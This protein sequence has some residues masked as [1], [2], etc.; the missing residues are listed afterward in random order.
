MRIDG[1]QITGSFNL[2]GDTIGDLDTLVTTSSLNTYTSSMDTTM[3]HVNTATHSLNTFT[4]SATTR[5]NSI[6]TSS[7]S[8]NSYTSSNTTNINAIHTSTGSLNTFTSS[9]T[10]RLSSIETSTGSLNTFT[11]S[12]TTR[13]DNIEGVSG[14]YATTGSNQFKNDQVITGSLTVTGFIETQ[15]LRTTYISSSILYRSGSTK[16]G[17]ELSDTHAFTGSMLISG[18]VT[19]TGNVG[20]GGQIVLNTSN[21]QIRSGNELRFYRPDNAIYT[22][23]YDGGGANGFVID[24]RNGDGFSLQSVGTNQLRISSTGAATFS[25]SVTASG[26][27]SQFVANGGN[28]AG[29]GISL[30]TT[31]TTN[32]TLRRNWG[33]FTEDQIEGDFAIKCSTSAGG[34]A[35]VGNT[36]LAILSNGNV[37]IST[38]NPVKTLEVRGTLAISNSSSSYWYIDRDDSDGRFKI[39][40]DTDNERLSITTEGYLGTTVTS[41]TIS[42]GDLLGVLSFISKDASTYSSGGIT[43]IRSYATSTYNTGNVAGDLRFYVSNG[44]Q[45]ITG[46]YLFGTEA[47]RINSD[48]VVRIANLTSNGL[49]G[50][51]SSGNLRVVNS[52]YTEIATGT[53]TY[54][55][56]SGSPW[57]INNSFPGTIRNYEDEGMA[58]SA[59]VATSSNLGRGVTFDLGSAKAVR[60]IVERGYNTKNLNQIIA[61]YST[62]NSNWTDIYVYNHVY[63]NTQ[64]DMEFNP[65][66]AISARY[67]RWFIHSWTERE[68]QNYYTYE[69]IIYT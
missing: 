10:S 61:Q 54:S 32:P 36:R 63:G 37:G 22:Q 14:S 18:S 20:I 39:L 38:T 34:E 46:T 27:K 29:A 53:I 23:L 21:N 33:I 12:A 7:G 55:M 50:T 17:D 48:G 35:G 49:V 24:N 47:M 56:N 16:F 2:N 6:E 41:T 69:S 44:L 28:S 57:G 5:L 43:N 66:G 26:S 42:S 13:L 1:P 52:E 31:L 45:N 15:E 51:D 40:T 60:K 9:A 3:G 25:S 65:T 64:K 11:S 8:L 4:S 59:G 62:D 58:G 67:W 19:T 30:N 68:V